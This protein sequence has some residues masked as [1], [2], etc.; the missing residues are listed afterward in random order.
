[1]PY[2]TDMILQYGFLIIFLNV[3][4]EQAGL[5]LPTYPTLMIAGALS[6]TGGMGVAEILITATAAAMAADLLWYFTGAHLGRRVLGIL[7]KLSL[8]P[9]SCVQ[10]TESAFKRIGSRSLLFAKFVP[11]AGPIAACISGIIRMRMSNFLLFDFVGATTYV[12]PPVVLGRIF[13]DTIEPILE[14]FTS[15][16]MYG[17]I[18]LAFVL[19]VFLFVRWRRLY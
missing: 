14:A 12:A 17:A 4:F 1:M 5:P 7:C 8:A 2:I 3:L 13:H 18:A 9:N 6:F 15:R 10:R 16:G 19:A 11:S